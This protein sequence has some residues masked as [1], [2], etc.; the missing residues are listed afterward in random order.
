MIDVSYHIAQ[1]QQIIQDLRHQ[2]HLIRDQR[3]DLESR[4][5][6]NNEAR[7][8]RLS[9]ECSIAHSLDVFSSLADN[10]ANDRLRSEENLKLRES[11]LHSYRK[12]IEVRRALLEL[13]TGLMDVNHECTRNESIVEQ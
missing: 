12:Q 3:D 4:L 9:G 13:D 11:I 1:Y 6:A 8:S 2:V 7:F 10:N 5:A